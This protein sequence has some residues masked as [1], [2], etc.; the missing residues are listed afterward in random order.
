[1]VGLLPL[2][3]STI[4]EADAV[5]RHPRLMELIA[6]F[7][8]RYPE[9]VAQVAPTA[10]GYI[11]HGG[12]R[13]LSPLSR[14]RLERI[15]RYLLDE[16][17]F[18]S[19]HGIRSLSTVHQDH[20]FH[21]DIG[22]QDLSV[23]YLPAESNT[24]MFGGNSNWRGPVWMPVNALII[25]GLLNLYAF[26]GD[27]FT[28]E[29]PTGSGVRMTLFEVAQEISRRLDEHLP[30]RRRRAPAGLRRD[31]RSSRT[32]RTGATSSCST[33]TSTATTGPGS[34]RATRP[35]GRA[36]SPASWT[37]SAGWMRPRARHAQGADAGT[38]CPGAGGRHAG[39]AVMPRPRYPSLF[40]VNTRVRLS[41]LAAGLG[42]P[43][44]LDD[45][46]DAE[47]DQLAADGFDLV[48]FLG[49]WQTGEAA[50]RVS[51]SNPE[52][53]AEYRR[54][55]PDFR[56]SDV[57]GSCFAVRD[58]HVHADFGGDEALARLRER[59]RERGLRLILDFV[60]NHVAPDHPWVDEH[61]DFFIEGTQAQLE[62]EP[63]NWRRLE[64]AG[65]SGILAY[66]RDPYFAGWPDTLQL[67]YGNPALQEAMLGELARIAGAVRRRPL[68]H[69]DAGAA[70]GLRADVGDH[71]EPFWPRA[72]AAVRA[73]APDFL[74]LAEVYWDLEWT[75]QQQG[76]DYTYD[77]RLYD[78]L[79]AGPARPVREH[80]LAGLDF[81]DH[82]ARFLENHDEPRAAAT[83]PLDVHRG[84]G[85][86]HVPWP[87]T[88]LPPPGPA[89]GPTGAHPDAP[90][91]RAGRAGRCGDRRLLRRPACLPQGSGVPGRGLAAPRRPLRVVWE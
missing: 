46:P 50:R 37:S 9:V 78:R 40:Q 47:L 41:E 20:P 36:S 87:R 75:L 1:M 74:F 18:L 13:L 5:T 14:E 8:E 44:T 52:W 84:G 6:L 19:P 51:A 43:A 57:C 88:A 49:V 80:L 12:R 45:V 29:C 73:Q 59:L 33:S 27:D 72:T 68:R 16:D 86:H 25:R 90:G 7:R 85:R 55:L 42:R 24:G 64:T 34:A 4:F 31:A 67:N 28:V 53:L 69:G 10:E 60:P 23:S 35:A 26:Y 91:A 89:R 38:A 79:V 39:G 15:L 30:P 32:I 81:Q 2:C 65:G 83:F 22:G 71:G 58:Y 66:G 76:F 70:G 61:R 17:E 62:E 77:K 82:L 56:E 3:A 11:G 54:V 21:L 48:W 63:Q